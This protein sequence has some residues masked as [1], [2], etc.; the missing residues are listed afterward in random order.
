M[1]VAV[2]TN[3]LVRFLLHD[4]PSWVAAEAIMTKDHIIVPPGVWLELEWVLRHAYDLQ[5]ET[6]N[7]A[8]R[9]VLMLENLSTSI[10]AA[11]LRALDW[12]ASGLDFADALHLAQV[13]PAL[14]IASFDRAFRKRGGEL[15]NDVEVFCP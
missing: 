6:I 8:I 10:E 11:L 12:H 1:T 2:D 3:V 14:R 4:D 9:N 5:P 7:M 13:E 15:Q